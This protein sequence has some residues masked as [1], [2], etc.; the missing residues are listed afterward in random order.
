MASENRGKMNRGSNDLIHPKLIEQYPS[1]NH[2][3]RSLIVRI[4][5]GG[6]AEG[7]VDFLNMQ[8]RRLARKQRKEITNRI[9]GPTDAKYYEAVAEL[10]YIALWDHLKWSFEK[11]PTVG[12]R[13]PDFKVSYG[14][15]ANYFFC[16]VTVVRH[17]HP[18]KRVVLN[19]K[20]LK[21]I[22]KL[23]PVTQPIQQAHRF[24]MKIQEK[25]NKYRTRLG[26]DNLVICFFAYGHENLFY[27]DDFQIENALFGDRKLDFRT[28]QSWYE[29]STQA[30]AHGTSDVGIFGFEEYK[31][32]A[33]VVI[34]SEEFCQTP[35]T[36]P[37]DPARGCSWKV[38]FGF[39]VYCNPL[40]GWATREKDPFSTAGFSVS[41]KPNYVEF[42]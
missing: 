7:Y 35:T 24:L 26:H 18:V 17:D 9:V 21:E 23:P 39:R 42:W 11:D 22:Q 14:R 12:T 25:L 15:E 4:P 34:C 8:L 30:T 40:G 27:L 41:G 37:K 2:T 6:W 29:P 38:R 19:S 16:D 20:S 33:A 31:V 36:V 32:V 5:E 3:A 1:M 28:G 10:V 13:T